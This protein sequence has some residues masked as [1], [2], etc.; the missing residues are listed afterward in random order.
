M[1]Y[2]SNF[3]ADVLKRYEY[4]YQDVLII[5]YPTTSFN[6]GI[7]KFNALLKLIDI[8]FLLFQARQFVVHFRILI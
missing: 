8:G 1:N 7:Y 5:S 4:L 2:K 6:D 3:K